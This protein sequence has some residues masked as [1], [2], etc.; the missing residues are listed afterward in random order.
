M[1]EKVFLEDVVKEDGEVKWQEGEVK[2]FPRHTWDQ[3]A[4]SY[5]K[6]LDEFAVST[7]VAL[8]RMKNKAKKRK[9][10]RL[11]ETTRH[12]ERLAA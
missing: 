4:R 3:I 6:P 2:D 11:T 12:R 1:V 8:A 9:R 7:T 10:Q 5:G